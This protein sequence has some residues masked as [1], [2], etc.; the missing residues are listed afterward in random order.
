MS[1]EVKA[2]KND[3]HGAFQRLHCSGEKWLLSSSLPSVAVCPTPS[4]TSIPLGWPP[5]HTASCLR[6]GFQGIYTLQDKSVESHLPGLPEGHRCSPTHHG[7]SGLSHR[8]KKIPLLP[9]L[10][11]SGALSVWPLP[12]RRQAA[13]IKVDHLLS[14]SGEITD[15]SK[16]ERKEK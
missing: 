16:G 10:F 14:A 11:I 15:I 13:A 8:P 6:I 5:E 2:D 7:V 3:C 12:Q 1:P 9:P 4:P